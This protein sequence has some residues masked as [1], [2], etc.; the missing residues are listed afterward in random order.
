[1]TTQILASGRALAGRAVRRTIGRCVLA[2]IGAGFA[3]I[4]IS[5]LGANL[6][7]EPSHPITAP[8]QVMGTRPMTVLPGARPDADLDHLA[9]HARTIDRLYEQLMYWTSPTCSRASTY[10]SIARGC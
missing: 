2:T 4:S 3:A 5:T 6:A 9:T 10:A 7:I 1:M 8:S